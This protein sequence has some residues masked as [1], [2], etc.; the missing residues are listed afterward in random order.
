MRVLVVGGSGMLGHVL[1][2]VLSREHEVTAAVRDPAVADL[3]RA[4][5]PCHVRAL[6]ARCSRSLAALFETARPELVVNAA[7]AIPHR[8]FP[9]EP[10]YSWQLNALFPHRLAAACRARGERLVHLGTDC[11]FS[12]RRGAYAE[13]D[14]P[15]PA[16]FYG[17]TK[18][19]GEPAGGLVLRTSA[20][21]LS[22]VH[23]AGLV[24]WFLAGHGPISGWTHAIFNGLESGVLAE[25]VAD[26]A[27]REPTLEG[28]WHVASAP[29]SKLDFL[30][31]LAARLGRDDVE[32][33]P[34]PTVRC[35]RSLDGRAFARATGFCAPSWD[36]Q[37]DRI[38]DAVER[39]EAA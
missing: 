18:W 3:V 37:L 20:V 1:V 14:T 13:S 11:V 2:R 5:G 17:H 4:C 15:D 24:E 39:R 23:R 12:G 6:D 30:R 10:V 34:D 16:T 35:D 32:I 26:L 38:A 22:L 27:T 19:R 8:A 7:G 29:I 28:T 25:V 36:T 21:G 9:H 33:V 31:G